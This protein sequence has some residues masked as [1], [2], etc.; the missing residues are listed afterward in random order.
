MNSLLAA[1]TPSFLLTYFKDIQTR[2]G[3]IEIALETLIENPSYVSSDD[4]GFNGQRLRKQIFT[5]LIHLIEFDAIIETGTMIGNTT[6][7]MAEQSKLPIHS[8]ESDRRFYLMAKKRLAE[9]KNIHFVHGDSRQFLKALS[10]DVMPERS[11]FFY[12]DAHWNEDLPL[13]EELKVISRTWERF[14]VMIDD[15]KVPNDDG[16]GYDHYRKKRMLSLELISDLIKKDGLDPFFPAFPSE[17]ETGIKR[18]CVILTRSRTF[19]GKI[20]ELTSLKKATG[21]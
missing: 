7:Y 1:L 3:N 17:D 16:Y 8:C 2:L 21:Y 12:L 11:V 20:S 10:R 14:V 15:F 5:D 18:G 4:V 19:G 13:R 9:F 6:G